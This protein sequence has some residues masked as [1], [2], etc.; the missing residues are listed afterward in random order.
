MSPQ[1]EE[2]RRRL[3]QSLRE[4]LRRRKSQARESATVD[5]DTPRPAP[6]EV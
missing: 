4:N 3:A 6:D 5:S 1:E 2:R